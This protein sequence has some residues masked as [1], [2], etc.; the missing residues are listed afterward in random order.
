MIYV[1]TVPFKKPVY[2]TRIGEIVNIVDKLRSKVIV[3]AGEDVKLYI[4]NVSKNEL[5]FS[6][7]NLSIL[8]RSA[9][10]L[11]IYHLMPDNNTQRHVATIQKIE[12]FSI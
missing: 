7:D 4:S 1:I 2:T 11:D 6:T 8:F 5:L 9:N 12:Q 10:E 3:K